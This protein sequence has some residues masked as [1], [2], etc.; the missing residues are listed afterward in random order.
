MNTNNIFVK[1]N[2]DFFDPDSIEHAKKIILTDESIPNQWETET[3]W[4]MKF[5]HQSNLFN[6]NS[7]VLDWGCGIG[8]L[9]KPII[10]EFDCKVIGVDFQPNMLK[11]ATEY[12]NHPNFT[13]MSN[14]EFSQLPEDYFTAG[15]AIWALQHTIDTKNIIKNIRRKLKFNSKFCVFE[16]NGK[17]WPIVAIDQ[18]QDT[19]NEVL[20]EVHLPDDVTEKILYLKKNRW[21]H[22]PNET[23]KDLNNYFSAESIEPFQREKEQ[24]V[25]L[26]K[27]LDISWRGIFI[28]NKK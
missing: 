4:T 19:T 14:E 13:A 12:V 23:L 8:R 6:K 10:E 26:T 3:K 16:T 21:A 7:V 5:F 28:N 18:S 9:A 17:A 15:I 2:F 25:I 1:Y 24:D 27:F 20:I 22:P 11:Y